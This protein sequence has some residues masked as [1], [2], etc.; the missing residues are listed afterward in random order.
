[1]FEKLQ[2]GE[3]KFCAVF[4]YETLALLL[5]IKYDLSNLSVDST[6]TYVSLSGL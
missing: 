6:H 1:M 2:T 4:S 5:T 3:K